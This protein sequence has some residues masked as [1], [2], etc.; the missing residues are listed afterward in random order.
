[1]TMRELAPPAQPAPRPVKVS[2]VYCAACGYEPQ[3]L[4][5]VTALMHTFLY[6]LA[7][8]EIIPWHDG[9]FDVVVDGDL[10][11]AMERDGGFPMVDT[12]VAAV[13]ERTMRAPHATYA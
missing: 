8:I 6:D 1:M 13:R 7:A 2:I 5:L 3:T 10:V 11:H 12:I 4:E 9:A